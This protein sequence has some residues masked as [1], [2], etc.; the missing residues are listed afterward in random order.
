MKARSLLSAG[1]VA[2]LYADIGLRLDRMGIETQPEVAARVLQLCSD[3]EAGLR[4]FGA[5]IKPDPGLTGR[6]LHLANS[7]FFAQVKPVTTLDRAC[8]L[9]GRERL[10]AVVL[11][12]YLSRASAADP[13]HLLSRRI[14]GESVFRACLSAE[15]AR[16]ICPALASEAFVIGLM[17]DAGIPLLH[18]LLGPP[19]EDILASHPPTRQA[20]IEF[21]TL[22]YTHVDVVTALVRRW[23]LPEILARPIERHHSDPGDDPNREPVRMLHR[24]AFYVGAVQLDVGYLPANPAPLSMLAQRVLNV[25]AQQLTHI[26]RY[27]AAEY[28][29]MAEVFRDTA[30][31]IGNLSEL[32]ENAHQQL[33]SI[34]DA[35]LC[36]QMRAE[37]A[38]TLFV[39]AGHKVE[40]E[41]LPDGSAVAYLRDDAGSR[42][43]S[44]TFQ[45]GD[46]SLKTMFEALGVEGVSQEQAEPLDTYLRT[47]AA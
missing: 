8:V 38:V 36:T 45:P 26:V 1:E 7:A 11:G 17:M 47:R 27:A 9:L 34:I 15:L 18:R 32:A 23:K 46:H 20:R 30:D 10:K 31:V 3:P 12:F 44:Y 37:S 24:L 5:V 28:G 40:I 41:I 14:W 35:T 16:R 39:V 29:A 13:N 25:D 21:E 4:E 42:I 43:V 19:V 22:P 33:V 6:L 2:S